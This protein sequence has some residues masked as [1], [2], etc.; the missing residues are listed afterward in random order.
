MFSFLRHLLLKKLIS[1]IN[2]TLHTIINCIPEKLLNKYML[3]IRVT[4]S[5][6]QSM[7]YSGQKENNKKYAQ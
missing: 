7:G 6:M 3:M 4:V 5:F 1:S 2:T